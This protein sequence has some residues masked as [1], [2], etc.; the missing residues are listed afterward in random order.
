MRA[1]AF[2]NYQHYIGPFWQCVRCG[3]PLPD[4]NTDLPDDDPF[5]TQEDLDEDDA[6]RAA[7]A[8]GS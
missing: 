7:Q 2:C 1:C 4:A 6:Q 5:L 3:A 8:Q